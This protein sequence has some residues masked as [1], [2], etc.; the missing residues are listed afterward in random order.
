MPQEAIR[1]HKALI[2]APKH[3]PHQFCLLQ[4]LEVYLHY[5][6]MHLYLKDFRYRQM[7]EIY[8]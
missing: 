8:C 5:L 4:K 2:E 3:I 7:E 6:S 1:L